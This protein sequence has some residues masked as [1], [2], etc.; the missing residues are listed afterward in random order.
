ML[1]FST[2]ISQPNLHTMGKKRTNTAKKKQAAR[3]KKLSSTYGV[4]V[5]KGGTLA[6]HGVVD[7][8]RI[9]GGN[10]HMTQPNGA[11]PTLDGNSTLKASANIHI[12]DNKRIM[13]ARATP[14]MRSQD[15][16][17]ENDEFQRMH[18]SLEER[19][20]ALQSRKDDQRR[21]KKKRQQ[22]HKKGWGKFAGP[23]QFSP[24]TLN[25]A[26]KMT[27]ELVDDAADRM[28][29]GM[30]EIGQRAQRVN[31]PLLHGL[32]AT[33]RQS[34]LA[35]AA[36]LNWNMRESSV[37]NQLSEPQAQTKKQSLYCI[38]GR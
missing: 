26:P 33:P 24:A 38:R 8:N 29:E 15:R 4:S 10:S 9:A 1:S 21:C 2:S 22:Y 14:A 35:A 37:A 20:L 3:K 13:A 32:S 16:Q 11:S 5:L 17:S 19:S 36:S 27:Q 31:N 6:K 30:N 23:T 7:A 12:N 25:L 18:A 28:A 34:S